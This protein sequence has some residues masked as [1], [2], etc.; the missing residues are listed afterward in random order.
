MGKDGKISS[1]FKRNAQKSKHW[2]PK[3]EIQHALEAIEAKAVRNGVQ[4]SAK[5]AHAYFKRRLFAASTDW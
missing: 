1:V 3:R 5:A 4:F 2:R